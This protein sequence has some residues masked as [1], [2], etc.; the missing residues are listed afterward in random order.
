MRFFAKASLGCALI[1]AVATS[2]QA[3]MINS[4]LI[5]NAKNS[6]EDTDW[7]RLIDNEG[8]P[9]GIVDIGDDLEAMLEFGNVNVTALPGSLPA[10][11]ELLAHS[12][13]RVVWKGNLSMGEVAGAGVKVD[14]VGGFDRYDFLFE[15]SLDGA[16]TA[17]RLYEQLSTPATEF[18]PTIAAASGIARVTGSTLLSTFGIDG[19]STDF[20]LAL[21]AP[22][23]ISSFSDPAIS[24][25]NF[26]FG[27]TMLSNPGGLALSPEADTGG[28]GT[29]ASG[30]LTFH[31]LVG[32]GELKETP[33][34]VHEDWDLQTDTQVWFN[35]V[36]EPS[37]LALL[38]IGS[39]VY[40][41]GA[42]RRRRNN[43]QAA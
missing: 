39:V 11:Y 38:G 13:V 17:I 35:A 43:K 19:A 4:I 36:P 8:S 31:D 23:N 12:K 40:G 24:G 29:W 30:A 37:T 1:L 33:V 21:A 42:Y 6:F 3:A 9:A 28:V 26:S 18:D 34:G 22:E 27:L 20:W 41:L 32:T 2:A 10:N 25:A 5:P 14:T 16:G 15:G 7:E